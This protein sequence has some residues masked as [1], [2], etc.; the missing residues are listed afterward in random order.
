MKNLTRKKTILIL[1]AG[2]A[3]CTTA[4]LLR[5][6]GFKVTVLEKDKFP[7]GGCRTYLYG[8]HPYTLGPRIFFSRDKEVVKLLTSFMKI[9]RF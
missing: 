2:F 5:Q 1:G 6:K 3:G 4:Y 8:G 9:R 7:G